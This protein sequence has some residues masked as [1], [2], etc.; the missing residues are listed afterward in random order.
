MKLKTREKISLTESQ[1]ADE[2]KIKEDIVAT[3]PLANASDV[4]TH[5]H[6]LDLYQ[7]TMDELDKKV[8]DFIKVQSKYKKDSQSQAGKEL[9]ESIQEEYEG[10]YTQT[11]NKY[12]VKCTNRRELRS[13][14]E[15]F[16]ANEVHYKWTK[17][18]DDANYRYEMSFS[19][20]EDNEPKWIGLDASK[21]VSDDFKKFLKDNEIYFEPSENGN[22]VHFE[23]RIDSFD[24]RTKVRDYIRKYESLKK[25]KASKILGES[26]EEDIKNE[27]RIDLETLKKLLKDFKDGKFEIEDI[28]IDKDGWVDTK[29]SSYSITENKENTKPLKESQPNDEKD[30]DYKRSWGPEYKEYDGDYLTADE[31]AYEEYK[32]GNYTYDEYVEICKQEECQPEPQI[33]KLSG[34]KKEVELNPKKDL[35]E[36][37]KVIGKLEDYAPWD[38]AVDVWNKITSLNKVDEFNKILEELYPDGLSIKQL[39]DL[40]SFEQDFVS[41]LL[42]LDFSQPVE[43]TGTVDNKTI[44]ETEPT[45]DVDDVEIE[46][47]E[48]PTREKQKIYLNDETGFDDVDLSDEEDDTSG[49]DDVIDEL[50]RL[51]KEDRG[52]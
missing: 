5:N 7:K 26:K 51:D 15:K 8:E 1:V 16:K 11:N 41:S 22:R 3:L 2:L 40:L 49:L 17:L 24:T 36:E 23:I 10:R 14:I 6:N 50:D 39:N 42:D 33:I 43:D 32:K 21:E 30:G 34:K 46:N 37:L 31:I 27:C 12:L 20:K 35:N 52:E 28:T 45:V 44:S 4:A 19:L 25:E 48:T 18:I 38:D 47:E 29:E 13:L 9:K